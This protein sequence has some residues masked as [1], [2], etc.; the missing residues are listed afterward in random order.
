MVTSWGCASRSPAA[1]HPHEAGITLQLCDVVAAAV[2]HRGAEATGQLVQDLSGRAFVGDP[3]LDPFGHDLVGRLHLA[4]E[5]AVL[6]ERPVVHGAE[7]AHAPVGL[8][9]LALGQDDLAGGLVDTGE[10]APTMTTS[11]PAPIALAMSPE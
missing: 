2:A 1:A 8:V 10:Q 7:R 11:A 9:P 5:V 6:G 3:T 4:L